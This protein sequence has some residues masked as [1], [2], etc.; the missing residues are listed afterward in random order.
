[1]LFRIMVKLEDLNRLPE[2]MRLEKDKNDLS[3]ATNEAKHIETVYNLLRKN[4]RQTAFTLGI[5]LNTLKT[6]MKKY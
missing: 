6:K 4:Q 5:A 1:M 2:R 3:L